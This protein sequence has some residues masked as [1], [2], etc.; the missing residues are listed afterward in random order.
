MQ[1]KV[2]PLD[3]SLQSQESGAGNSSDDTLTPRKAS[4]SRN[5]SRQHERLST[6]AT[7]AGRR[8]SARRSGAAV[9]AGGVSRPLSTV[10]GRQLSGMG[11]RLVSPTSSG[12]PFKRELDPAELGQSQRSQRVHTIGHLFQEVSAPESDVIFL[13]LDSECARHYP[14]TCCQLC[15]NQFTNLGV[16]APMLLL[17]GHSYCSSCLEKACE[18][19][20]YP[21]ALKCG[22]CQ[23]VTP[24]DQLTPRHLPQNEAV[25]D[26]IGSKEY[27]AISSGE[28][29]ESCAECEQRMARVYCSECSASYCDTCSRRAHEGSRVR[30][31]HKPVSINLK[32]RPQPTCRKHPGQSCM[33]YCVTDKQ[34]MCVLCKFYN[35]H[36]FH[37]FELMTKV[38]AKYTASVSENLAKL[39]ELEKEQDKASKALY[40]AVTEINDGARKV[41]ERLERHFTGEKVLCK[42]I[43]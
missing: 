33:L 42:K 2:T 35:Q 14:A 5:S 30:A 39:E 40:A 6:P 29:P 3:Q 32:P 25:L 22:I 18:S 9:G 28:N 26:L 43:I 41:Q 11:L 8:G 20:D 23:V 13:R 21:A 17:C 7:A 4:S 27:T 12:L 19:Y 31:R 10:S 36:R 16:R 15:G 34:P 38:A 37:K 1:P 24:L